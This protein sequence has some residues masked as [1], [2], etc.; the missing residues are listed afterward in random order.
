MHVCGFCQLFAISARAAEIAGGRPE[1]GIFLREQS[2][3]G[4]L[5]DLFC[6]FLKK[7][8]HNKTNMMMMMMMLP[9][10]WA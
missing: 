2:M 1:G 9:L 4:A 8:Q 10:K 5:S 6:F 7:K 3:H